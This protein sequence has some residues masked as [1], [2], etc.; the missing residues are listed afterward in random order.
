MRNIYTELRRRL[1]EDWLPDGRILEVTGTVGSGLWAYADAN[2]LL[3]PVTI[4]DGR[5]YG[6][7]YE[8]CY[9]SRSGLELAERLAQSKLINPAA[10]LEQK[11]TC[12]GM[13]TGALETSFHRQPSKPSDT[14]SWK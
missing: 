1:G 8:F 3:E 10:A 12:I 9:A 13:P 11:L 4:G 5:D 7:E 2:E 6:R 14:V